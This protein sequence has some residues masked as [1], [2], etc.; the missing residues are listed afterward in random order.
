VIDL[1][2]SLERSP[3]VIHVYI[4]HVFRWETPVVA[5]LD[6][7][8]AVHKNT[9]AKQFVPPN[10]DAQMLSKISES[11]NVLSRVLATKVIR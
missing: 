6:V 8:D 5:P 7:S 3:P 10:H 4:T 11:F 9:G 1:F 2:I